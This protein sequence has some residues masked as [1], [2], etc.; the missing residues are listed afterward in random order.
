MIEDK[1]LAINGISRM[2]QEGMQMLLWV[3]R[4]SYRDRKLSNRIRK[5][6]D[7]T[8]ITYVSH[9]T[10]L[11]WFGYVERI[12]NLFSNCRPTEVDGER[13]KGT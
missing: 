13:G 3:C 11:R 9:L 7:I 6:L 1:I 5:R 12:E 4:V 8:N 10:L 2:P